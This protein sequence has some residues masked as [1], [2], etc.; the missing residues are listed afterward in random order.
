[1]SRL[2]WVRPLPSGREGSGVTPPTATSAPPG[3]IASPVARARSP[4]ARSARGAL[5]KTIFLLRYI[6]D[7][8]L[9][10]RIGA[11][12]NE[13]EDLHALRRLRR[14][15]FLAN[16]GQIRRAAFATLAHVGSP[17]K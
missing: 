12:L 5:I 8:A 1:M 15:I 3:S 6:D 10:R 11:Q 2:A 13:G 9:R 16:Q 14:F 7:E 17:A 4:C